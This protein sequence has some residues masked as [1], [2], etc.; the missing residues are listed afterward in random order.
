MQYRVNG[1]MKKED[2]PYFNICL[3]LNPVFLKAFHDKRMI[4]SQEVLD[5]LTAYDTAMEKKLQKVE[6]RSQPGFRIIRLGDPEVRSQK[7]KPPILR[8]RHALPKLSVFSE[9]EEGRVPTLPVEEGSSILMKREDTPVVI[10]VQKNATQMEVD[11]SSEN[12]KIANKNL[13]NGG[14]PE[15]DKNGNTSSQPSL[16]SPPK[17][18][19]LQQR[20][21]NNN[22]NEVYE[23]IHTGIA[24]SC[25]RIKPKERRPNSRGLPNLSIR[26]EYPV[27]HEKYQAFTP[28]TALP[29][30]E[31]FGARVDKRKREQCANLYF[32]QKRVRRSPPTKAHLKSCKE[33]VPCF[34]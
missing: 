33:K 29:P 8:R 31:A 16:I 25:T 22:C 12:H 2:W 18:E 28:G 1:L 3:A 15:G 26:K 9:K 24:T 32:A 19:A 30:S 34:V 4:Q 10:S 5:A 13:I 11:P 7:R 20:Q 14:I 17:N 27:R 23:G 6:L 21:H